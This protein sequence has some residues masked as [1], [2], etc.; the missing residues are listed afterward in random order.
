MGAIANGRDARSHLVVR[1]RIE[2]PGATLL[3]VEIET[4]RTHQIRVHLAYIGHPV[5]G[6][7]IYNRT[8]GPLG[9]TNSISP[10]QFLHAAR[11]GFSL[12]GGRQVSFE[13]ALPVDLQRVLDGLTPD[14]TTAPWE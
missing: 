8:S 14:D 9:G 6:D 7:S 11:L 5:V 1:E 10:R 2:P 13:A 12:P 3:D 4:G